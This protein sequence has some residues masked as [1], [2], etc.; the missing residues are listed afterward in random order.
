[1]TGVSLMSTP[2]KGRAIDGLM[3]RASGALVATEYFEA[4]RLSVRAL[5]SARRAGDFERIARICLPLLE[6]RRQK[7]QAAESSG[8]CSVVDDEILRRGPKRPG[9]YLVRAPMIGADARALRVVADARKIPVFVLACE[10]ETRAG[11]WPVVAVG[12]SRTIG[13]ITI[14]TQV[15]PPR[16]WNAKKSAS[17]GALTVQ[18]FCG[19]GEALGDAAIAKVNQKLP[20]VYRVDQLMEYLDAFPDHEK[21]HQRLEE[22]ARAAMTE[23]APDTKLPREWVEERYR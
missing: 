23:P 1:M 3:D 16:G 2:G 11:K 21:L 19:A 13:A 20:A 6:A 4:E 10:P 18:W 9:C 7:R 8:L 12:E 5:A 14:R 22:A 17:P 15:D